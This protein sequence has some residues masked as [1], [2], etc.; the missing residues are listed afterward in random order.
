MKRTVVLSDVHFPF[1]DRHAVGLALNICKSWQPHRVILNGDLCD[2]YAVSYFDKDPKRLMENGGLQGEIDAFRSFCARLRAALPQDAIVDFLPG[3]HEQRLERWLCRNSGVYGLL[4]LELPTLLHLAD[5]NINY[6][7]DEMQLAEGNLVVKH[8]T[9]VRRIAG[10]SAHAELELEKYQVS[11]IT[12]HTHRL[13]TVFVQTRG[14]VRGAWENG[15]LCDL[16]PDYVQNPN[17]HHGLTLVEE[18]GERFA[19]QSVPFLGRGES[20]KAMIDGV[21]VRL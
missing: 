1:E 8:G 13:A 21:E 7:E 12:G 3:N 10:Y 9:V 5:Y 19:A 6:F 15:C 11:T 20:M 17:W 2:F 4:A 14:G 16:R 18:W